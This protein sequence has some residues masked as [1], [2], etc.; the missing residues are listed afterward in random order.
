MKLAS[1]LLLRKKQFVLT[2]ISN[3]QG[4]IQS[5]PNDKEFT[6]GDVI[7]LTATPAQGW[8]FSHW[9]GDASGTDPKVIVKMDQKQN[10]RGCIYKKIRNIRYQ[11]V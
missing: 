4:T 10:S 1:Q 8:E 2:K 7:T 11:L 6:D 5:N 9:A 3:G